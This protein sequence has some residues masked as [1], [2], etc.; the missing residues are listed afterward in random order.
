M[1]AYADTHYEQVIMPNIVTSIFQEIP[2]T[3]DKTV[4]LFYNRNT[5]FIVITI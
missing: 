1:N 4:S 2:Q 5:F 3:R